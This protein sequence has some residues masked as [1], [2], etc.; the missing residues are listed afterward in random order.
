M[1]ISFVIPLY[2]CSKYIETCLKSIVEQEIEDWECIVLDDGSTDGGDLIVSNNFESCYSNIRLIKLPHLGI[3]SVRNKGL[4]EARGKY[5]WFIDADD[6]LVPNCVKNILSIIKVE[7]P[8]IAKIGYDNVTTLDTSQDVLEGDFSYRMTHASYLE[9]EFLS[10]KNTVWSYI[11]RRDVVE[12]ANLKFDESLP[13]LEDQ[14]F[15][16]ELSRVAQKALV[17]DANIYRRYLRSDS[18]TKDR[19]RANRQQYGIGLVRASILLK[20]FNE[21]NKEYRNE[22]F[23]KATNELCNQ[24]AFFGLLA[25][26]QSLC[27]T[28]EIDEQIKMLKY[29]RIYPLHSLMFYNNKGLRFAFALFAINHS[30]LLK[31]TRNVLY[32]LKK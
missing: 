4:M 2:N 27:K 5:I 10:Q 9:S 3:S 32:I 20:Q 23:Y 13:I 18:I 21:R 1:F 8:D 15:L 22:L 17:I 29:E 24:R 14:L 26:A 7:L 31:F 6:R 12:C 19:N 28:K 11:F 16:S 30:W 25:M